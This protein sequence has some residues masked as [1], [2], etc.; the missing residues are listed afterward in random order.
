[1]NISKTGG[2]LAS[3][4]GVVE[5][6]V[7]I[8]KVFDVPEDK[9][10]WDVGHQSYVYKILTGRKDKFWSLRS[11]G[12][13]SGFPSPLESSYDAFIGGHSSTS[14]SAALGIQTAKKLSANKNKAIAVIGDGALS[15]GLAYEGLNNSGRSKSK[16]VVILNDNEMSIS[17]NVGA[18]ARYL[19]NLRNKPAYFSLK[20][21]VFNFL[22]GSKLGR[23]FIRSIIRSK[24]ALKE[25]IYNNTVFEDMGFNYLGPVDGHNLPVLIRVLERAKTLNLPA[26]VHVKTIKGKGYEPAEKNPSGYHGVSCF[27]A[28]YG[29]ENKEKKDFSYIFGKTLSLLAENDEDICAVSAAMA[30]GTGLSGFSANFPKRFFDVGIAEQHAITF[31]AGLSAGGKKP[32]VALYS[33]FLQRAYDQL[34]HDVALE[35]QHI[36]IGVD[37]AGIT[38]ED[39][40]THQGI[41]D[42][43][44]LN[45]LPSFN[46]LAPAS[47]KELEIMLK[48]ALYD[49]DAPVVVRYPKG[50]EWGQTD[51]E[52]FKPYNYENNGGKILLVT[53]GRLYF[54][55]KTAQRL[56][57]EKGIECDILKL[58]KIKPLELPDKLNYEH[59]FFFEEGVRNGG[60][61]ESFAS[62]FPCH[63][64]CAEDI[65]FHGKVEELLKECGLD[66]DS[67]FEYV[68]SVINERENK[69]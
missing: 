9:I 61:A 31:A 23:R 29:C 56:L 17:Q 59:I 42:A 28:E 57:N 58:N 1:D 64:K 22:K 48:T 52:E 25:L 5:L 44:F 4:L 7:A 37:R 13:L 10:V 18:M 12:G 32:V 55:I 50:K 14:V 63:I 54:N 26:F 36:V 3:N 51:F 21:K 24:K 41:Y 69:A 67:V 38:G 16:M 27:D 6:T 30:D 43:A 49:I 66:S 11:K 15:G 65:V 33:S 8:L 19:S 62:R 34:L 47:F 53:Y 39:G 20:D 60:I 45:T 68:W 35:N 2:H 40:K 46:V